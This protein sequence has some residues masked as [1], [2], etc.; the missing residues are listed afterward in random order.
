MRE[1]LEGIPGCPTISQLAKNAN[2]GRAKE[3]P[4]DPTDLLFQLN[5][6]HIPESFIIEDIRIGRTGRRHLVLLT[7]DQLRLLKNCK[8]WFLDGTF[9]VVKVPFTQLYSVHCYM[10][11]DDNI[12]QVPLA[13]VLMSGQ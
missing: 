1:H 4:K 9:H 7:P 12:K 6:E 2:Y 11:K 5:A 8:V 13:F 10:R 3:R